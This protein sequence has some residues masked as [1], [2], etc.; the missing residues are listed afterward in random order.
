MVVHVRCSLVATG[1]VAREVTGLVIDYLVR[2]YRVCMGLEGL[3]SVA[4]VSERASAGSVLRSSRYRYSI[5]FED[6]REVFARH[7][8]LRLQASGFD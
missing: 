7:H 3:V 6:K 2:R 4:M 5:V 8:R 1:C